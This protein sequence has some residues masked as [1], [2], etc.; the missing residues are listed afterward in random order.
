MKK[1]MHKL[2]AYLLIG[3]ML[4]PTSLMAAPIGVNVVAGNVNINQQA[5]T[6]QIQ[7]L[8]DKAIINWQSFDI[9][10]KELVK[11]LQPGAD[12]IALNRIIG[13][14]ATEILGQ[15]SANGR[16]FILNPN[17]VVF[18]STARVD[19]SGLL[20]T[21]LNIK[22]QDFLNNKF[23]FTQ[24]A[25]V[26]NADVVNQGKINVSDGGFAFLVA[27]GVKNEGLIVARL[28]QVALASGN[29]MTIDFQGNGLVSFAVS[30]D[31]ANQV[32][33]QNG[34]T[35]AA[36]VSNSGVIQATGGQVV[37]KGSSIGDAFT[38]VVSN[39]GTIQAQ[40]L[41]K[42]NG[43]IV[44][45]GGIGSGIVSNS[46]L[47]D[48]SAVENNT[49]AGVVSMDG[50][51]V[52]NDGSIN[53]SG[54]GTGNGGLVQINSTQHTITTASS[55]INVN[56]GDQGNGGTVLIRSDNHVTFDGQ[57]A[58][59]G[60]AIKG[61]GGFVDVSSQG[62]VEILGQVDASAANGKTG[63]LLIDPTFIEI[64]DVGGVAFATTLNQFALNQGL[65]TVI[66]ATSINALTANVILQANTDITVN[67]AINITNPATT[68]TLQAGR[69]ILINQNITTNNGAIVMTANDVGAVVADR[70]AGAANITMAA[71]TALNAGTANI[72][73]TVDAV[74]NGA[75]GATVGSI[76]T[77]D[78]ITTGNITLDSA[79]DALVNGANFGTGSAAVSITADNDVVLGSVL[80]TG[81]VTL[82]AGRAVNM[83]ANITGTG[84]VNVTANDAAAAA[85]NR[86]AGNADIIQAAGT[87]LDAGAGNVT[88]TVDAAGNGA[89]GST[90]IDHITTTGN[91]AINSV[92]AITETVAD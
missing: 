62:Q 10:A 83:N 1:T 25:T 55:N 81:T 71:G 63:S 56:G 70:L 13:G 68:L 27:P 2:T 44:L 60:G 19:V 3:L 11:F 4:V 17:G 12:S 59:K 36:Q 40:S 28:G 66:T 78:V 87:V 48:V 39:T 90:K 41:Q 79:A 18:G 46:G 84:A 91:L 51:F 65:T 43:K 34:Q 21:T 7:Q 49:D 42:K 24:D 73:L 9:S 69:S 74:G 61:D 23:N 88:L 47:L 53:A 52:G 45:S 6:T 16:I 86:V 92:G 15:L 37:M 57:V 85:A 20:A 14:N 77:Q 89:G 50:Y 80:N 33:P 22:N 58:T 82:A 31:I 67:T 26:A 32:N 72:D 5:A 75:V 76:T 38:S 64:N 30:G 8:S 35:L 54:S 29:Q